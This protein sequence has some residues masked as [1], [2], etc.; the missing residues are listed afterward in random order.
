MKLSQ[1]LIKMAFLLDGIYSSRPLPD[2]VLASFKNDPSWRFRERRDYCGNVAIALVSNLEKQGIPAK[3]VEGVFKAD[4][5][6]FGIKSFTQ[7]EIAEMK[8]TGYNPNSE[9]DRVL[10]T[11]EKED[12]LDELREIPHYWVEITNFVP[13]FGQVRINNQ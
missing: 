1:Q 10:F 2:F 6:D 4:L 5:P 3:R 7:E 8:A 9:K 11:K 13:H 12:L